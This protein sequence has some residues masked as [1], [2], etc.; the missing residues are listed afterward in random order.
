MF[1]SVHCVEAMFTQYF[2]ISTMLFV[3]CMFSS[4]TRIVNHLSC[5]VLL[6]LPLGS[7][8]RSMCPVCFCTLRKVVSPLLCPVF[9]LHWFHL[10]IVG[11]FYTVLSHDCIYVPTHNV[12]SLFVSCMFPYTSQNGEPSFMCCVFIIFSV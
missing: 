9:M 8:H 1:L 4:L 3:S 6:L 2:M 11:F 7:R 10:V 12:Y 5:P